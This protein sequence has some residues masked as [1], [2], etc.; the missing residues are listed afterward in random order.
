[1]LPW[2]DPAYKLPETA[3]V[4]SANLLDEDTSGLAHEVNLRTERRGPGA[5]RC[6]RNEYYRAG[7]QLVRL[8]NHA[9]PA[10]LLLVPGSAWRAELVNV[11][12]EHACSP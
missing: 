12:P 4:H 11:T 8:D 5:V 10:A 1:M 7:Q 6:R 3:C 9:V 2:T